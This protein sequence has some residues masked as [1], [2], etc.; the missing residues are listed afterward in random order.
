MKL[1]KK[2]LYSAV[3]LAT[4]AGPTVGPVAQFATSGL[5]VRAAEVS[6][7]RPATTTV[8]IY[9]LVGDSFSE[10]IVK[11]NGIENKDGA[12]LAGN[13]E[14]LGTNVKGLG[15]VQFVR[16]T[17]KDL[18]VSDDELKSLTTVE[19]ADKKLGT[20]LKDKK[21]LTKT[22]SS[23]KVSE[24][25]ESKTDVKYLYVEDLTK[26]PS[27]ISK[28]FA[29][30][31]VLSLPQANSTGEGFLQEINIY[32]KN[33]Q[34]NEPKVD[35]D[36]K[37]LSQND[38]GFNMGESF[39]W[40]LKSTVPTNLEDFE[41]FE[42]TD[43]LDTSL[44]FEKVGT[45]KIGDLMLENGTDYTVKAEKLESEKTKI[46]V[47]FKKER[48]P[49]I[50]KK[51]KEASITLLQDETTL[52]KATENTNNAAFLVIPVTAKI[53]NKAVLGKA[54]LN[55]FTLEYDHTPDRVNNPKP[56]TPEDKPEVHTGGKKFVKK[57][58]AS[59]EKT[60]PGAEFELL[61]ETGEAVTWTREMI[62]ANS[63]KEY[64]VGEQAV[65]SPI[66]LKSGT[67]GVFE[68]KGLAFAK[69]ANV[70]GASVKYQ[71]KETKAPEGYVKP[72]EVV[73]FDVTKDSYNKSAQD[74]N[75]ADATPHTI[76]NNK[77]P[78]IP[79]TGGIGTAIF[80]AIGAAVMAFA[81]KGMKRRTEEN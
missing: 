8:N 6:Q 28:A 36:V 9:K 23:G 43:E 14:K 10:E 51:I 59:S 48:L 12:S 76:N 55:D 69:D 79:N 74:V 63:N 53:N 35:K 70:D 1:S 13:Y 31:F 24:T 60:L 77:R 64:I 33:V 47:T 16:Y 15:D 4:V 39:D 30:P 25:L 54:I 41:K 38:A 80:V 29:V 5:V 20:W 44:N 18:K 34:T 42:F 75:I 22:D 67:N 50:S 27:N 66:K 62:A 45:V 61:T 7:E 78:S 68:I 40:F 46:T 71:L 3:V 21:E 11:N 52:K 37:K 72:S 26:S 65:G 2:L 56:K 81:A 57:D 19:L 73:T 49:E 17:V 32:P 58:A